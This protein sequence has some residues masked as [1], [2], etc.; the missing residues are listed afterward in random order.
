MLRVVNP[1]VKNSA[2]L[3]FKCVAKAQRETTQTNDVRTVDHQS[4]KEC[5]LF[6]SDFVGCAS[7]QNRRMLRRDT[8]RSNRLR[9]GSAQLEG[10]SKDITEWFDQGHSELELIAL[11][12]GEE[13]RR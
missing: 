10:G 3:A 4:I 12:D 8:L 5:L 11:L 7:R 2:V 9:E 6:F 1:P 13:V